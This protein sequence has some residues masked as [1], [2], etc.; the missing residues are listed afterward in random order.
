MNAWRTIMTAVTGELWLRKSDDFENDS[1][2]TT[3]AALLNEAIT[4][5]SLINRS[6]HY[7]YMYSDLNLHISCYARIPLTLKPTESSDGLLLATV[8]V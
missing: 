8:H 5:D 6:R 4:G 7:I 1:M 3:D 2:D